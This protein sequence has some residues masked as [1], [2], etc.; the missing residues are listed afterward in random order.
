MAKYGLYNNKS[1][2]LRLPEELKA[3]FE[4]IAKAQGYTMVSKAYKALIEDYV[5]KYE[6]EHGKIEL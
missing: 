5:N 6:S 1:Y 4:I 3:K 2:N